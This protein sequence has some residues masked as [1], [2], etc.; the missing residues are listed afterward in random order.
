M[1][2]SRG[3]SKSAQRAAAA[4]ATQQAE[5]GHRLADMGEQ[6]QQVALRLIRES[7]PLRQGL[8]QTLADLMGVYNPGMPTTTTVPGP[9]NPKTGQPLG[10]P[11]VIE[12]RGLVA[13]RVGADQ[14][15]IL[16]EGVPLPDLP[17]LPPAYDLSQFDVDPV[18]IAQLA[19]D[20]RYAANK[21]A[22]ESQ[23]DL[24][25]QNIL[26]TVPG[27]R[28]SGLLA[29]VQ[30]DTARDRAQSMSGLFGALGAEERGRREAERALN[31]NFAEARRAEE[32]GARAEEIA[33]RQMGY[34]TEVGRREGLLNLA[35]Q[36]GTQ[37]AATGTGGLGTAG[38]VMGQG[39]GAFQGAAS[40]QNQI[41]QNQMQYDAAKKGG[42][43]E[44]IGTL[45]GSYITKNQPTCYTAR[46]VFGETNLN[47]LLFFEWKER[48]APKWFKRF[49][50]RYTKRFAQWLTNKP[51]LQTIVRQWMEGR[52]NG[53]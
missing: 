18:T 31:I 27:Q 11:Q 17:G 24:A 47:W 44:L 38:A 16:F 1:G 14:R 32:L 43:G 34:A 40:A 23:Y 2:K 42:T 52:I 33:R 29:D 10:P 20:P 50:N 13:P 30:A 4:A 48:K 41:A 22:I 19:Q 49:Y 36:L 35:A 51:K 25:Q 39:A 8:S 45:G 3:T 7:E 26:E 37:G 9:I 53:I 12:T 28:Y 5:L 21:A 46:L 15:G 6:D